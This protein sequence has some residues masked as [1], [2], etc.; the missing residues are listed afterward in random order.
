MATRAG[1]PWLAGPFMQCCGP[2][3]PPATCEEL[4]A[5]EWPDLTVS[6][7][8]FGTHA[9]YRYL[10]GTLRGYPAYAWSLA[11][12]L[13]DFVN[14]SFVIAGADL[15]AAGG[16]STTIVRNSGNVGTWYLENQ[17]FGCSYGGGPFPSLPCCFVKWAE[18]RVTVGCGSTGVRL[19]AGVLIGGI[20]WEPPP[21]W[22]DNTPCFTAIASFA[23][24]VPIEDAFVGRTL[25]P[26]FLVDGGTYDP[27][28]FPASCSFSWG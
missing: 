21:W 22:P 5:R 6:L 28:T 10:L 23:D 3:E 11:Q 14:N 19:T 17:G 2:E 1:S 7:S 8:G 24:R 26:R 13:A 18:I 25:T 27:L 16:W 9:L 12:P 20:C 15:T 4:F